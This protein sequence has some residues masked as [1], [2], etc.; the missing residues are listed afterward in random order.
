MVRVNRI[1]RW[2]T[3]CMTSGYNMEAKEKIS[4]D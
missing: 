4:S 3:D 1:K 2:R